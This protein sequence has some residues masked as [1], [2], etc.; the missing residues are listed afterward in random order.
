MEELRKQDLRDEANAR[1]TLEYQQMEQTL[2]QVQVESSREKAELA[3]ER[4]ELERV[5][6]ELQ[7]KLEAKNPLNEAD[8]RIRA[9][10]TALA[11][12]P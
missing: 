11:G 7:T 6:E 9:M 12:N 10:L 3:R 2:L 5:K 1:V 8:S 4:A